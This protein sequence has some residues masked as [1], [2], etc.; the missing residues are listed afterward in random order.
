[1]LNEKELLVKIIGLRNEKE[2]LKIQSIETQKQIDI[3]ETQMMQLLEDKDAVSTAKYEGIGRIQ[4][5]KPRLYASINKENQDEFFI[6]IQNLGREDLIKKSIH[7]MTLNSF[8]K[9]LMENDIEVPEFISCHF[10]N[11]LK[12]YQ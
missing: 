6:Y 1:M 5:E 3:A 8:V 11:V 7:P 10:K 12:L 9:E 2:R 4:I